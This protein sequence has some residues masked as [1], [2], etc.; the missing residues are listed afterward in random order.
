MRT[1]N[2]IIILALIFF[3]STAVFA[4][5]TSILVNRATGSFF[6]AIVSGIILAFAFQFLLAN[7]AVALGITAIGDIREKRYNRSN[8]NS[9]T[10]NSSD[11][12]DSTPTGVKISTGAGI[13]LLV[14]LSLS[15]FF[16]SLL[17]VKLSLLTS[18]IIGFTLGMVIWA[19]TL[20]LGV[21]LDSKLISA[22]TGSVFGAIKD[23][24]AAGA[25][26]VGSIF[27]TGE[28]S[29]IKSTARETVKA[30]HDE[31][32]QEYDLS[33]FS[34]KLDEYVNKL[35][36]QR[37]D[38]DN[39][40]EHLAQLLN[41]IEIREQYTPDD[42]E[43]TKR[44][45]LEIAEKQPKFSAKDKEK[46][47]NAFDKASEAMKR[48]G[49]RADK[50]MAAVDK[51]TPGSEEDTRE[52]RRK[53]EQY[54]RRSGREEVNPDRL[55]EDLNNILNNPREAPSVIKARTSQIDRSTI[56][57]V[58]SS[59]GISEEKAEKILSIA[60]EVLT[61]IKSRSDETQSRISTKGKEMG[62]ES[63]AKLEEQRSRAEQAIQNWFNRMNQPE[64]EYDQIKRDIEHMMDDPKAAP[65]ILRNRLSRLDRDS[66]ISLLSN[67]KRI[68]REQ[69]ENMVTKIEEARDTVVRK[70]EEI[71][72]QVSIKM[73]DLKEEAL[74]QAEATRKTAASAAWWFFIAAI[75]SG[76]ASALGGILAYTF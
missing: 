23:A 54:L 26:T 49:S 52:Y 3:N 62:Q 6:M 65:H 70:T 27:S 7:L 2:R 75:V 30:I 68:S 32:R 63:R 41:E 76:G 71:E 44:L 11:S 5:D 22:L 55:K 31:I 10:D 61:Q 17:A 25:S 47:R 46:L 66:L 42:P 1:Q 12:R 28:K 14:T 36:P 60:E 16:A 38:M 29:R 50:A 45:F 34:R 13:F 69:A 37:M 18:N 43:A 35:E 48:E 74:H 57:A 64:L 20:L 4:Q 39:I 8:K 72:R 19:A 24:M 59:D 15:L 9:D 53:V 21:Y 58:L 33:G 56:K 51:L 40:H 73:N 67:N